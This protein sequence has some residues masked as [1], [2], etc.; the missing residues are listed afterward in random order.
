MVFDE[1]LLERYHAA[2][3][4]L[5]SRFVLKGPVTLEHLLALP[6]AVSVSEERM[7]AERLWEPVRATMH[8]AVREL[9]RARHREGAKLAADLRRQL[10]VIAQ[11]LQAIK[12]QLPKAL[13]EQRRYLRERLQGLLGHGAAVST[14]QLEQALALIKD[15]DIHEEMVRLES[16]LTHM[17]QALASGRPVGKQLDFIAQEL[18]REANTMGAKV[19]DSLAA[20]HVV[21]IKG[22]IEKIREQGQNLE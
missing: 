20:Q 2:L 15:I 18:M 8:E 22:C 7:P 16:H 13:E 4:E 14:G 11:H 3:I 19:N 9:V 12:R 21:E 17:R 6:Q 1:R 10:Q 5:K